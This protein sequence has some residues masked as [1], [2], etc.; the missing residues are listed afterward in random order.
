MWYLIFYAI[1]FNIRYLLSIRVT[2]TDSEETVN[3]EKLVYARNHSNHMKNDVE[4]FHLYFEWTE[5]L[6]TVENKISYRP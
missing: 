4:K 1:P 3:P 5:I 2:A 6:A